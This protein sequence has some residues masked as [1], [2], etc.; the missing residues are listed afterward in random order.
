MDA[1]STS[2][3]QSLLVTRTVAAHNQENFSKSL[4][5]GGLDSY[6][7]TSQPHPQYFCQTCTK[8]CNEQYQAYCEQRVHF[9]N[10]V[11]LPRN[12]YACQPT[13]VMKLA[14]TAIATE[15]VC[16]LPFPPPFRPNHMR[17]VGDRVE[18]LSKV[19]VGAY[20]PQAIAPGCASPPEHPLH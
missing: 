3:H 20:M 12:S 5:D 15:T 11:V 14:T 16:S 4:C 13:P 9:L 17:S 7:L 10:Q 2:R 6:R 1:R 19:K 18:K 8:Q